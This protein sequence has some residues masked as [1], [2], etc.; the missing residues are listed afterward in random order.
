MLSGGLRAGRHHVLDVLAGALFG[1]GLAELLR[2]TLWLSEA[3]A[4]AA[5]A[6][7]SQLWQAGL[8]QSMR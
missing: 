1:W 2:H 5:D 4:R 3:D 6:Y 7:V 8:P